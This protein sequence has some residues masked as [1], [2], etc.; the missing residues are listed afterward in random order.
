MHPVLLQILTYFNKIFWQ[1]PKQHHGALGRAAVSW[2]WRYQVSRHPPGISQPW[3]DKRCTKKGYSAGPLHTLRV[4]GNRQ[5]QSGNQE[6]ESYDAVNLQLIF[7]KNTTHVTQILDNAIHLEMIS[8]SNRMQGRHNLPLNAHASVFKC[9][10]F[11]THEQLF[12][13]R[14]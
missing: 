4:P 1:Q 10:M 2:A 9:L 14:V 12:D 5:H 8:F 3:R 7:Y 11:H 6:V 13:L